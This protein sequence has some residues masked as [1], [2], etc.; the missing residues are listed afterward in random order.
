MA[1]MFLGQAANNLKAVVP[2]L[3]LSQTP[4]KFLDPCYLPQGVKLTEISKMKAE[5]LHSC[6]RHWVK[7]TEDGE[8]AFRFKTVQESDLQA[9]TSNRK[10]P[11]PATDDQ[12][13][14][15]GDEEEEMLP[16]L[17][18]SGGSDQDNDS[19]ESSPVVNPGKG[20]SKELPILWYDL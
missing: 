14:N 7:R 2:W 17:T 19:E 11:G 20:K 16:I 1:G 8:I 4:E 15:D 10:R 18:K 12:D 3:S 13:N 6:L 9:S 5:S